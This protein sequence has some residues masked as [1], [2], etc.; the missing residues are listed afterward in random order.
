MK[1]SHTIFLAAVFSA[2]TAN[3]AYHIRRMN[4]WSNTRPE[5]RVTL[6]VEEYL[7]S[8]YR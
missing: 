5:E 7:R 4:Q 3:G 2:A 8:Y 6:T 1:R